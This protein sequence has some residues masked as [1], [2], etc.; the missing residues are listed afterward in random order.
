MKCIYKP[1]WTIWLIKKK[2]V[3]IFLDPT[4]DQVNWKICC[5]VII[6]ISNKPTRWFCSLLHCYSTLLLQLC[7]RITNRVL[8]KWSSVKQLV[9][10]CH[11][12]WTNQKSLYLLESGTDTLF[13]LWPCASHFTVRES[14]CELR[15]ITTNRITLAGA[16]RFS[17]E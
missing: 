7:I 3:K 8:W 15:R 1:I 10:V 5:V 13:P 14:N 2:E 12:K 9:D 17:T 4:P 11:N 16:G 6:W